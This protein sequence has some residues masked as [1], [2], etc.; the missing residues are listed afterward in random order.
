MPEYDFAER[1]RRLRIARGE[2]PAEESPGF[3]FSGDVPDA[4]PERS[5]ED[6]QIDKIIDG[7]DIIAAYNKWCGKM[8]PDPGFRR[9]GIMISCPK[10]DHRDQNPS[11]WIN[12]DKQTWHCGGCQEGGDKYDIA[13]FHF[14]YP[15]PDYKHGA[16]FH[17]LRKEMAESF[18]WKFKDVPGGTMIYQEE[19][20]ILPGKTDPAPEPSSRDDSSHTAVIPPETDTA[21]D[22]Q[23]QSSED[24]SNVTQM[25]AEDEENPDAYTYPAISWQEVVPEETF[26]HDYLS[27]CSN[28]DSPEEYHF[29][30]G[31]LALGHAAGRNVTLDDARPVYGNLLICLLGGTGVG[32][33]RSRGWLDRVVKEAMPFKDSGMDTSG[34]KIIGV[35]ASGEYLIRA[36]QY[37]ARDPS[38]PKV[39]LGR[40]PVNGIVDFDE[41]SSLLSRASRPGNTLKPTIMAFADARDEVRTGSL[42]HG[43]FI[44]T[45]PFCSITTSTQP[46][47]VRAILARTDSGS[48]FLNR[49]VFAG[50]PPKER[51]V[52]GGSH[53]ARIINLDAAIERLKKVYGWAGNKR[54]VTMT[55]DGFAELS[56]FYRDTLFPT[57][58]KDDTDLLKRL[59]LLFKK[60]VLLFCINEKRVTADAELVRRVE[61]LFKYVIECYGI[62]N[63]Q[64][65]VTMGH[66]V[67]REIQRH[68]M[69]H[70]VRTKRGASVRDIIMYTKRKNYPPEVIRKTLDTL[71]ALDII[72]LDKTG[73]GKPGRPTV[74]Y[75]VVNS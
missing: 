45:E 28:D 70:M 29:W 43:D 38:N 41:F 33:S 36:F 40:R 17:K 50:G 35:P 15:A 67:A 8:R 53:S 2:I 19:H 46:K 22:E 68:I 60:L 21:P 14:H 56:L 23:E 13:A 37:E 11:A 61:A 69:R 10:P 5:E 6:Q 47:A 1:R 55:D 24:D 12:L 63:E 27:A 44:A 42:T 7:I 52:L 54:T 66:E 72:E 4:G 18:G 64:I 51:E 31:L 59:D 39:P 73:E 48:G 16:T 3:D 9:E 65:G 30:H 58:E 26:L 49:W 71:V 25:F 74:R 57:Q 62:L 20:Q 32:K 75:K 34:V